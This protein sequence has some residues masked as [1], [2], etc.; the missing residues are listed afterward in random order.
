M[1]RPW[2]PL[3][4]ADYRADTAHLN[5]AQHGAYLLLI[6]HYWSTGGL[7]ADDAPLARIACMTPTEW[8]KARSIIAAFF[9]DG[10]RH[11]RI[12]AELARAAE[13]SSKRR[14]SAEQRHSKSNA[15][16]DQ[17]DTHARATSPSQSQPQKK[18]PSLRS[19]RAARGT[20]FPDGE[21]LTTEDQEYAASRGLNTAGE[22]EKFRDHALAKGRLAKD[23]HAAW[24]SWVT[25]PY[26]QS[27]QKQGNGRGA[28]PS[29]MEAFD[30]LIEHERLRSIGGDGPLLDLTPERS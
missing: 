25:S 30:R 17:L 1:N 3:Y 6:M 20:P 23:W 4:V 18:E 21:W 12:D 14:A 8:R 15:I 2:M 22:F 13:I 9:A 11:K 5:A 16:A 7:P 28:K 26:Q 24:R 10:W 29:T 19:G 27:A